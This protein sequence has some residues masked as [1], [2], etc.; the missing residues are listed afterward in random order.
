MKHL[1]KYISFIIAIGVFVL[2]SCTKEKIEIPES[3]DPVF[4]IEGTFGGE[5]ISLIAGD[6]NAFMHTMTYMENG[7]NLYSGQISDGDFS[8]KLGVYDGY[9]DFAVNEAVEEIA[10]STPVFAINPTGILAELSKTDFSNSASINEIEWII[11]G[12]FA[13]I[14]NV[15]ITEPGL[16]NVCA[17]I[18]F[19]DSSV[20]SLCNEMI[21]GYQRTANCSIDFTVDQFGYLNAGIDNMGYGVSQIKWFQDDVLIS[22][23]ANL[24]MTL[25]STMTNISA[26]VQFLGGVI[27][28]T[29]SIMVSGANPDYAIED[30]T[31]FEI[32][33]PIMLLQ[34]FNLNLEVMDGG[35]TYYSVLANNSGSTINI[36]NLEYYG[37]N[38]A[39][40]D[41]Y[42]I[43]AAI[44]AYVRPVTGFIDTPISFI[45]TFGIEIP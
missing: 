27:V 11:N 4:K 15:Q 29:K 13:G 45:T 40:K 16:Y 44:D 19:M 3:N 9:L 21:V 30:F 32:S 43:T 36:T 25:P 2:S 42:K 39:N 17:V 5:A 6:N 1:I 18:T 26:E 7:V 33:M 22:T 41:V 10:N 37:K 8:V 28:R 12:Q 14:N 31:M 35:L 34:D 38:N 24:Q 23:G 20:D